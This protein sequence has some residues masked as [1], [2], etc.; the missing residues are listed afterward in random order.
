MKNFP[1]LIQGGMGIGVSN[2]VLARAV[3]LAGQL[4]VISGTCIDS[5]MIRRLQDGDIDA[6]TR[7]AMGE[8]PYP[9]VVEHVLKKF[10]LPNGRN[11]KAYKLLSLPNINLKPRQA[12]IYALASFV[13]VH[14]AKREHDGVVGINLLTKIQLPTLPTLYGA[15]LA[16]V[17]YVLMGAGIP[18]DIPAILEKL[19]R[20]EKCELKLD[21]AGGSETLKFDPALMGIT[22][23]LT[24]PYF[25]PIVSSSTLATMLKRKAGKIDGFI[26]ENNIAGGHNAP[27][28][29]NAK[30]VADELEAYRKLGLP[31][32]YAGGIRSAEDV[33]Q[34]LDCGAKGV[35]VGSLFALC[36]E[37][38]VDASVKKT[39]LDLI[40]HDQARVVTDHLASP[41]GFPFKVLEIDGSMSDEEVYQNRERKCDLGYLRTAYRKDDGKVGMRCPGEPIDSFVKKGGSL[42]DTVGRKC[43]CN[44]LFSTIGN[45]QI[46]GETTE[47]ALLTAGEDLSIIKELVMHGD[48][49]EA[50][51]V[52]RFLLPDAKTSLPASAVL[53]HQNG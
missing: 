26:I 36:R 35:Q 42:E 37:S 38:G 28:R 13:E 30:S 20:H 52:I 7:E 4:G 29:K 5:L 10:F 24:I 23:E 8:F 50:A 9:E 1:L 32:W 6:S 45:A 43:L 17:D 34:A 44:S 49:Y 12:A 48:S 40:K 16:G 3:S 18:K 51:D 11:G 31:F 53:C 15:M 22:S 19:S 41:T 14:L 27:E 33:Q 39:A 46:Q 25:L 47:A 2:W 21:L